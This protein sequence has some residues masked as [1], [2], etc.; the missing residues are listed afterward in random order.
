MKAIL[1]DSFGDASVLY[2]GESPRPVPSDGELL[3]RVR[4]CAL[5]RADILQRQGHYPPPTGE[6]AILG[7]ELAGEVCEIGAGITKW[8]V[9]DKVCGLVG[10]GAYA[11][12]AILR[13]DMALPVL[14]NWSWEQAATVPEAFLTAWQALKWIANT[15]V[16]EEVLIHAGASG[17][18]TAAI[19]LCRELGAIPNVTAS[20]SKH[21]FCRA[22]GA[23]VCIDYHTQD[24]AQVLQSD[25]RKGVDIIVDCIGGAYLTRNME[26]LRMD[27]RMIVLAFMG[28]FQGELDFRKVLSKRLMIQGSTLRNRDW[29]YKSALTADLGEFAWPRF[30]KG[31]LKPVLDTSFDWQDVAEAHRYMEANRNQGKIALQVA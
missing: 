6:S 16:G 12:Y 21:D 23:E 7:L 19:Q 13:E 20:A 11:E 22:L 1:F 25:G 4:A 24:F 2:L 17:V 27:G 5:N 29:S 3:V 18:G 15:R 26:V 9:G 28:G 31:N 14:D 30:Q 8:K 10:G